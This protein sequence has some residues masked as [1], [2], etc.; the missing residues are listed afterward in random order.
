[1][2]CNQKSENAIR[3]PARSHSR[4]AEAKIAEKLL[5]SF[6]SY[7]VCTL[8]SQPNC[9]ELV[10]VELSFLQIDASD[11]YQAMIVT[12]EVKNL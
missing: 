6:T 2:L 3:S 7:C 5:I 12:D 10:P 1:M 9:L 8:S 4:K 11:T